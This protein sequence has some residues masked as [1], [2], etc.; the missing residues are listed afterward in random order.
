MHSLGWLFGNSLKSA[1]KI[2]PTTDRNVS[3]VLGNS[4]HASW[5]WVYGLRALGALL[6]V[7]GSE[8]K[9]K[10][11]K[12]ALRQNITATEVIFLSLCTFTLRYCVCI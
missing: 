4:E 5:G 2:S 12:I 6:S 7:W 11:K 3:L 9:E 8:E 10:K 1:L